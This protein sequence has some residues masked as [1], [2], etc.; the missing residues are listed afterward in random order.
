MKTL[1]GIFLIALVIFLMG[2]DFSKHSIPRSE[3]RS[4]GPPKDGIPAILSPKFVR[5]DQATFMKDQDRV[6]GLVHQ[7]EAKAYPINILNWHEIVN[8][9]VGGRAVIITYCPL[10]G[11]GMAFDPTFNGKQYT[12][13]V[14]GLLYK[15]DVLMYDHQTES[16]WSQIRK[17]AVTGDMIGSRLTLLPL[18]HT[19]WKVWRKEHPGALIL[20][21][22][23]GYRR[24]YSRDPYASYANSDRLMFPVGKIDQRFPPKTWVLGVERNGIT[25]AYPFPDLEKSPGSITDLLGS[26][27]VRIEYD[28]SSRT[29]RIKNRDGDD[30]PT[31]VAYWFAWTA[32]HPK[33]EVYTRPSPEN[34]AE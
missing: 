15:S 3:I 29:A 23:T 27:E 7:G 2:F 19:T 5:A 18:I 21:P 33:T 4:G 1:K 9:I 22:D 6:L 24:D 30:L 25:K 13:G 8:D 31:V 12:F 32:F 11:T 16:L 20:S 14:S 34:P 26:E 28:Q 10:C 17:E